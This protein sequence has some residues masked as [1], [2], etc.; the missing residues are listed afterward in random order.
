MD[1]PWIAPLGNGRPE[2]FFQ[3]TRGI[4]Q[5]CPLSPFLYILMV[6]SLSRKLVADREAGK[7]LGVRLEKGLHTINNASF[8]DD[9]PFLGGSS[10]KIAKAFKDLI[11]NYFQ[12]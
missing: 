10:L 5:G 9:S 11:Q 2:D 1:N 3:A 7:M 8:F 6:D 12:V 4:R